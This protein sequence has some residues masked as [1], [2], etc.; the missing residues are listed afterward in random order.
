MTRYTFFKKRVDKTLLKIS[1]KSKINY[2]GR[3][4]SAIWCIAS[5]LKSN[6]NK[7]T[8]ILPSTMCIS[9]AIIFKINGF[10][11]K[12]IDVNKND[13][14]INIKK[15]LK[16]IK[17]NND[18]AAL[19]YVNLFGNKDK[20]IDKIKNFKNIF[21]IQ[22]LAQTFFH[23][24]ISKKD[25]FGNMIILSF[26]YSKIFDL[27]HGGIV[28]SDEDKF[29][30]YSLE[31]DKKISNNRISN[32]A[33]KKYLIWYT[34]VIVKKN[35]FK[36]RTLKSFASKIYL[37]KFNKQKMRKIHNSIKIIDKEFNKRLKIFRFYT[38]LFKTLKISILH[39]DNF[40]TPWRFSFLT[41]KR[42]EY[43]RIIRKRGYDA[44]SYYP[45][46]ARVFNKRKETFKNSDIIEKKIVN[47]WLSKNY[48]LKKVKV[49]FNMLKNNL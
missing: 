4:N 42:D 29:Y 22:D 44:S 40:F 38:K 36:E 11:L 16:F 33:K 20:N 8:I 41:N 19:F 37:V 39:S 25:I 46:I 28:L 5:Y 26:G 27:N 9:P 47:L 48:N 35:K 30:K 6:S 34:K 24:K 12:F 31:F 17:N 13:G 2:F 14:L 23:N 32:L 49:Q 7:R 1:N 18:I 10:K 15:S 43:L 21:V 3:A 45:N